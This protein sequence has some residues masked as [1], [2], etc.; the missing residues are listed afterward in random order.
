MDALSAGQ[1]GTVSGLAAHF[2]RIEKDASE[3]HA[4]CIVLLKSR[5]A[6]TDEQAA[7]LT[8]I[9][10][11]AVNS[12]RDASNARMWSDQLDREI[13]RKPDTSSVPAKSSST[14]FAEEPN[15]LD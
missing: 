9:Q 6:L 3:A 12:M 2:A 10:T 11:V 7:K 5:T 13:N 1:K 4:R 14:N 15:L 8:Q